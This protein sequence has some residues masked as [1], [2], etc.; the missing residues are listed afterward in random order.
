MSTKKIIIVVLIVLALVLIYVLMSRNSTTNDIVNSKEKI[1]TVLN[2]DE[3]EEYISYDGGISWEDDYVPSFYMNLEEGTYPANIEDI[4]GQLY[5]NSSHQYISYGH[6]YFLY[7]WVGSKFQQ[8]DFPT[9]IA[10]PD[11]ELGVDPGENGELIFEIHRFDLGEGRYLLEKEISIVDDFASE[12]RVL[13]IVRSE[14]H[15]E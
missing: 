3:N 8:L 2:V 6:E 12:D 10:F 4:H 7:R 13:Y 5:N 1:I 9:S 11:E 14:F 15:L